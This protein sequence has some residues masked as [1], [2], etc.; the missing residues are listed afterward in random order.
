[1]KIHIDLKLGFCLDLNVVG[2]SVEIVNAVEVN[3]K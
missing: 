2:V 3:A 1:M